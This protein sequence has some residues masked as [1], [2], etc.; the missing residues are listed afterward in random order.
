MLDASCASM[1]SLP[2]RRRAPTSRPAFAGTCCLRPTDVGSASQG[3]SLSGPPVRSL[4]L[5]PDRLLPTLPCGFPGKLQQVG[6]PH[7]CCPATGLWVLPRWVCLPLD[8]SAFPGH[9]TGRERLR[10]SGSSHPVGG[11]SNRPRATR[12]DLPKYRLSKS[13]TLDEVPPSLQPHYRTFGATTRYSVPCPALV[14][15]R[16]WGLPTCAAPFASGRQV[17]TFHTRAWIK[18][19]HTCTPD[20]AWAVS[21]F[22][23]DSSRRNAQ[24]P[25]LT[26]SLR[27]RRFISGSLSLV[28]FDPYLTRSSPA[29]SSTLTTHGI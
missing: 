1:P 17:P 26:P 28:S 23:P 15:R 29:F 11:A 2:P 3:I 25:V 18:V 22:R 5:R 8:T 27:F 16:L 21:R 20:A 7:H 4:A 24:P 12:K 10:S 19:T 9:T 6:F 13:A 14:L